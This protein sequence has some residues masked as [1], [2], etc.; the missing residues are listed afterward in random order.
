MSP[1][2][3][4]GIATESV[5]CDHCGT[6][7]ERVLF[8]GP[9]RLHH[10]PGLFRVVACPKCSWMRQ[11]PRPTGDSMAY[12]YPED[13][14]NYIRS[15]EEEPSLLRRWDRR[16]GILKRRWA[17]ERL[18]ARGRLLDVGCATGNFLHEMQSAGWEVKGVEP[19]A[20]AATYAQERHGLSVQVGT[21][22]QA[23][24]PSS[25]FD[26]LTMWDVFE[27][28]HTP[29]AD[30]IEAHRLLADGGLLVIRIPNMESPERRL[31]G[32]FWLGWDLPRH[33]YFVPRDALEAA[34]A[35]LGFVVEGARCIATGY[36]AFLLS[37]QFYLEDRFSPSSCW[38]RW[39]LRLGRSMLARL[40][41]APLF[42]LIGQLRLSSV[43]TVF[44]RKKCSGES[45]A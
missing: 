1:S 7:E 22:R 6:S 2:F 23:G 14:E 3:P 11:N 9:D 20:Q 38:P 40:A 30:V 45:E 41:F 5:P 13:Y 24:L 26:V 19:S 39:M 12:Y 17:V 32:P 36:A 42:W 8:E 35:E 31:F 18:Q 4:A 28:L 15:I 21:L 10:L 16:Y 37:L 33:L 44:A 27:H 29:W 34:L 43:I 25:S